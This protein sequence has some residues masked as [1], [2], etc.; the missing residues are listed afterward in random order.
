M[1]I[2]ID[3]N[4][5]DADDENNGNDNCNYNNRLRNRQQQRSKD[6]NRRVNMRSFVSRGKVITS[7]VQELAAHAEQ[8][9]SFAV[10]NEYKFFSAKHGALP[11]PSVADTNESY[12]DD[13]RQTKGAEAEQSNSNNGGDQVSEYVSSSRRN[14]NN[15]NIKESIQYTLTIAW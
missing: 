3:D 11:A 12:V 9:R 10:G 2:V 8:S 15:S 6:T 1:V 7:I 4:D 14:N 5:N 13:D